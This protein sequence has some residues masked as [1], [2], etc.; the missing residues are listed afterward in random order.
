M[1]IAIP[2]SLTCRMFLYFLEINGIEVNSPWLMIFKFL[3]IVY[4]IVILVLLVIILCIEIT[5][6]FREY[7]QIAKFNKSEKKETSL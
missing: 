4:T 1:W 7:W 3:E 6:I 2:L 5:G